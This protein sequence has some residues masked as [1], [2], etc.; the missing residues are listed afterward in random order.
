MDD[1]QR[2]AHAVAFAAVPSTG[3][4]PK[5][6][7]MVVACYVAYAAVGWFL[8]GLGSVLPDLEE[9]IGERAGLYPLLPGAA[10]LVWGVVVVRRHRTAEPLRPHT[11]VIVAGS[12]GLGVA[13]AV[14][15][16]TRWVW[17]SAAGGVAAAVAAASLIRLL[18]AMLATQRPDDTERVMVRANAW[19]SLAAITAPLAIGATI[20]VG[21]GWLP[22][23][24]LPIVAAAVVVVLAVRRDDVATRPVTVAHDPTVEA[25]PPLTNWWRE[26]T[27]LTTCIVIEFCFSYFAAT[28]L[29]DEIGLS[30]AMA[31]A[32][33]AAWGIGMAG[34]RFLVSVRPA[35]RSVLP[36]VAMIAAG[37]L[38]LWVPQQPALAIAGIGI[39]G[40]GASPL[41]PT[42]ATA[43]LARFPRS[44]DQGATRGAIASG[45]A[46]LLAPAIMVSLRALTDVRTAYLVVPVLL[47]VLA[48]L[49]KPMPPTFQPRTVIGSADEPGPLIGRS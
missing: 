47:I 5:P 30:T 38:L 15:G 27:V 49:A 4:P 20:A 13:V 24:A 37:F 40:L 17:L 36:S 16:M 32:G 22:G 14:M 44:P 9:D 34:G 12:I 26:W 3:R 7:S 35:P 23:M 33:A 41:Y 43:L 25:V 11:S 6:S 1:L 8:N 2:P 21:L 39:A 48:L 46:L 10:L 45:T 29:H 28:F 31:A 42:R 18:P 19:S